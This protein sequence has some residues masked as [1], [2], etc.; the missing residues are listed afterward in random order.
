MLPTVSCPANS[1]PKV[2]TQGRACPSRAS[3]RIARTMDTYGLRLER[4]SGVSGFVGSH[5]RSQRAFR[6]RIS[7]QA[8]RP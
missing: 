5:G 7:R 8:P 1:S 6:T 3:R 4:Y 2:T